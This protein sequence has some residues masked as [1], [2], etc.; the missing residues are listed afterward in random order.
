VDMSEAGLA[1]LT[2]LEGKRNQMYHDAVGLPT[3]GVGH[4]LTK[5]ELSS[6]KIFIGGEAISW[7]SGLMD[8]EV[9]ALLAG[10]VA[11]TAHAVEAA[12]TASLTQPQF[13]ALV[14]FAF[15]IG[16]VAFRNSTLLSQLNLGNYDAVPIEMR[17]WVYS[18]GIQLS[19]L[20]SRRETEIARWKAAA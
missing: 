4:L 19:G 3:I 18:K 14:S 8:S 5:D 15:N 13:D 11:D 10:D 17:R 1:M 7:Q 16:K 2:S 9:E 6:G 20:V 12:V